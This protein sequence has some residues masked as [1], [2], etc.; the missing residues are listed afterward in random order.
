MAQS[1]PLLLRVDGGAAIGGGHVMRCLALAQGWI[2]AGGRAVL[3]AAV[4]SP[5]LRQRVAEEGVECISISADAG[6]AADADATLAAAGTLGSPLIIVDGYQF[7]AE[8]RR[9]LR[10]AG[11]KLAAID[12]VGDLANGGEDLI[13]NPNPH[14]TSALYAAHAES[15]R[16]LLGT[17][18][19]LLRREFREYARNRPR[20]HADPLQ[21]LVTLGAADADNVTARV[22]DAMASVLPADARVAVVIGGSNVHREQIAAV[23]EPLSQFRLVPDPGKDLPALMAAAD[24]AVCAGGGTMWELAFMGVPFI[25][26]VVAENQRPSV[27]AMAGQ[28]YSG[29][30]AAAVDRDL[31]AAVAALAS[32]AGRRA[33]L[34]DLGR[35]LVDGK[36]VER[37]CA[38][39]REMMG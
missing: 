29:I 9:R 24:L 23:A 21:V 2:D 5:A 37:V 20:R 4:L 3:C 11:R 22:M 14:A 7:P 34:S 30:N 32:N 19:A 12:D 25:P 10:A 18:H 1:A 13:I 39:L 36:G 8:F 33:Q 28:G 27:A 38:A 17:S 35:R 31:P 6:S 26:I 16:L 15:A